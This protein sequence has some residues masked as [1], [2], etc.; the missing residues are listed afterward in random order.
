MIQEAVSSTIELESYLVK[1][2]NYKMKVMQVT[3][4]DPEEQ[5][6]VA[7]I[8][9]TERYCGYDSK[10]GGESRTVRGD[11]TEEPCTPSTTTELATKVE[12]SQPSGP[13]SV[14]SL[15]PARSLC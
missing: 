12:P 11:I 1:S 8:R 6:A 7:V 9:C 14:L 13:S 2:A 4:K 10:A 5:P 15:W 3:Q